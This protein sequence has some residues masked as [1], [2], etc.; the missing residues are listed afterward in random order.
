MLLTD[1][2]SIRETILF[3]LQRPKAQGVGGHG[4]ESQAHVHPPKPQ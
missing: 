1:N 4:P 3:P 2:P